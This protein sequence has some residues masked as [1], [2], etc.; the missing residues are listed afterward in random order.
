MSLASQGDTLPLPPYKLV[1]LGDSSVGKTSIVH[2]FVTNSFNQHTSNTIG[3]A[4][5]TKEFSSSL[6]SKKRLKF[7]IWDTAGQERYRSLTPM[8]YRNA[9]VALIVYDLNNFD[10]SFEKA[11]SW[12][13]QLKLNTG[14]SDSLIKIILVGNKSDLVDLESE[15]MKS[16]L[17]DV[18]VFGN[19]L[20]IK[21]FITSAKSGTNVIELFDS[22]VN[23]LDMLFFENYYEHQKNNESN[24]TQLNLLAASISKNNTLR[25][26]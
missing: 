20:D 16:S 9:K 14:S 10:D 2:R 18:E 12:I 23:D 13:D 24:P 6:N 5:I 3:A 22:L 26:C 21:T 1:L 25:C 8:Y 7:E 19:D 17:N 11:K 15:E 4:F